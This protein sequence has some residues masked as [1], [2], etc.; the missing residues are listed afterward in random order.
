MFL[1]LIRWCLATV[2]VLACA[3]RV[4]WYESSR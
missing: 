1:R 3:L 2:I 4:V